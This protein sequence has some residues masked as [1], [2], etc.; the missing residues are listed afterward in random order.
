M[1]I[2]R[3][4]E[5]ENAYV[6]H[7]IGRPVLSNS[8]KNRLMVGGSVDGR[9]AVCTG[10]ETIRDVS[11]EDAV[12]RN[13][14]QTLEEREAR[15]VCGRGGGERRDLFDDDVRVALDVAC[16]VD[17]LGRREI[18][19]VCVHEVAGLEVVNRHLDGERCVR[20]D[21]TE[22][23]REHELRGG[24]VRRSSDDTHWRRVAGSG[25][26]L[27]AVGNGQVGDGGAKV[28]EVVRG[29]Q[30]CNLSS[31]STKKVKQQE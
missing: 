17:L 28:D 11:G 20:L 21:S 19:L 6:D 4:T 25:R 9:K 29:C 18:V 12:L 22:V 10:R 27:L 15:G 14:V 8:D 2:E 31:L 7:V 16:S 13:I 24:H 1:S 23:V 3:R 30:R 26:D 5:Y